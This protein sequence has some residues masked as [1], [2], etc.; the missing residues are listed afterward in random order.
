[1]AP[2]LR[3]TL[4]L[5][6]TLS[7]SPISAAVPDGGDE[8]TPRLIRAVRVWAP[9]A[10]ADATVANGLFTAPHVASSLSGWAMWRRGIE[11]DGLPGSI[12]PSAWPFSFGGGLRLLHFRTA[13]ETTFDG[14]GA[15]RGR[16]LHVPDPRLT[17][18]NVAVQVRLVLYNKAGFNPVRMTSTL[19]H[20]PLS[21]GFNIDLT[22]IS[23]GP[24][25]A[26]RLLEGPM[27]LATADATQPARANI[28]LGNK[29]DRGTLHSELFLT[30][31]F[32][33]RLA[34]RAGWA[35]AATGYRVG[36]DRYQRFSNLAFVGVSYGVAGLWRY[37]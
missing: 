10:Y 29:N 25:R 36:N 30:Y 2:T 35:H 12:R 28:L 31:A 5:V 13:G 1:M 14:R 17:A 4:L 16:T 27:L 3:A 23:F 19:G 20:H 34:A 33:Q 6:V 18:L 7:G 37:Y 15:A 11:Y 21:L 24:T 26:T 32:G 8:A 9:V 22:G